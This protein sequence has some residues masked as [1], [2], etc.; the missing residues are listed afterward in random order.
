MTK[1]MS[2]SSAVL[3]R[4]WSVV[5]VFVILGLVISGVLV[6]EPARAVAS[7]LGGRDVA[8]RRR[9]ISLHD[10]FAGNI[11]EGKEARDRHEYIKQACEP[12]GVP[13]GGHVSS[14]VRV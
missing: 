3:A 8:G 10:Q 1:G 14:L 7:R 13:R 9:C 6:A 11:D 5:A 2:H 4:S 12:A